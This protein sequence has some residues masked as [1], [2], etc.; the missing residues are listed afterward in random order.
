MAINRTKLAVK[1]AALKAKVPTEIKNKGVYIPGL[2][3]NYTS[4]ELQTWLDKVI[5][6]LEAWTTMTD[7]QIT[8]NYQTYYNALSAANKTLA[9]QILSNQLVDLTNV[10]GEDFHRLRVVILYKYVST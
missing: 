1:L 10:T 9:N 2:T 3:A 5:V 4:T 8:S 7:A 6:P